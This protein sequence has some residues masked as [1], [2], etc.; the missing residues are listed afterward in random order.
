MHAL[1]LRYPLD[2]RTFT[3]CVIFVSCQLCNIG[4]VFLIYPL[5]SLISCNY[6]VSWLGHRPT[7]RNFILN[8]PVAVLT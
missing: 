5:P 4:S 2:H 6:A 3:V 1:I 7:D 8:P